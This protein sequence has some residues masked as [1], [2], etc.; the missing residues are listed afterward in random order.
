MFS[1][2]PY[3]SLLHLDLWLLNFGPPSDVATYFQCAVCSSCVCHVQI[4][5]LWWSDENIKHSNI[6][7]VCSLPIHRPTAGWGECWW[8]PIKK[9]LGCIFL[10]VNAMTCFWKLINQLSIRSSA[11]YVIFADFFRKSLL[12]NVL[13]KT[14]STITTNRGA[15]SRSLVSFIRW[16]NE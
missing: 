10:L 4:S 11:L 12:V 7:W 8:M 16:I 5:D 2:Y 15:K 6:P 13:L 1:W 9:D 3:S 14:F